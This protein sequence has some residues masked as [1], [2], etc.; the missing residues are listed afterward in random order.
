M[1][2]LTPKPELLVGRSTEVA[3]DA[4]QRAR[5]FLDRHPD[6]MAPEI[7]DLIV[8]REAH[9]ALQEYG[10]KR[11]EGHANDNRSKQPGLTAYLTLQGYE[12]VVEICECEGYPIADTQIKKITT[13]LVALRLPRGVYSTGMGGIQFYQEANTD[14]S[15]FR[16]ANKPF[17]LGYNDVVRVEGD[18]NELWQNVNY[19]WDG[20]PRN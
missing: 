6:L 11:L 1:E 20:T 13:D 5:E 9:L 3:Q 18:A 4:E 15:Q 10:K 14:Q 19:Q 17:G 12:R 2:R 8:Q 7:A 16:G